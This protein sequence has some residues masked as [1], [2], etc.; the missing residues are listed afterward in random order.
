MIEIW[1]TFRGGEDSEIETPK[2]SS[3]KGVGRGYRR[4]YHFRIFRDKPSNFGTVPKNWGQLS[5]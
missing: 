2:V 4:P 5:E 1:D 3:A